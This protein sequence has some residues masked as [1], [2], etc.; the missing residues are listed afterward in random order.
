MFFPG[1][2]LY[3]SNVDYTNDIILEHKD[4]TVLELRESSKHIHRFEVI[5]AEGLKT[6]LLMQNYKPKNHINMGN[7]K[8]QAQISVPNNK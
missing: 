3:P 7:K 1:D 8:I 5:Y 2:D 6:Q 4:K